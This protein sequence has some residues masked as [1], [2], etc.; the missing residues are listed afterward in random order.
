[1]FHN[2]RDF[3]RF[4]TYLE[5]N[6]FQ[7]SLVIALQHGSIPSHA[8]FE[9]MADI[10]RSVVP[11]IRTNSTQASIGPMLAGQLPTVVTV[12]DAHDFTAAQ[13]GVGYYKIFH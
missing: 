12:Q 11:S 1:L 9:R 13:S 8:E 6:K 5:Q 2:W 10:I 3:G 7:I 4:C